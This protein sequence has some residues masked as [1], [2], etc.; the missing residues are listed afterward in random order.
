MLKIISLLTSYLFAIL[1]PLCF[2]MSYKNPLKNNFHHFHLGCPNV[3]GG[4]VY[5]VI[6][7]SPF[8]VMTKGL[9]TLWFVAFTALTAFCWNRESPNV[10]LIAIVSFIGFICF[11]QIHKELLPTNFQ[12]IFSWLL[13]NLIFCA[14]LY[15]MNLGHWYLNVHGL[16]MEHL[17]RAVTTLFGL[18]FLRFIYNGIKLTF[19]KFI[20]DG[21]WITILGFLTKFDGFF[22]N[23]AMFFGTIFPLITLCFVFETIKLKNTQSTT[24]I[25]YVILTSILLGEMAY[26][27]Y[28][29]QFGIAL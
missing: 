9:V 18:I 4:V 13:G 14:S 29:I 12:I 17:K 24:G 16:P 2:W 28:L 21:E 1:Y 3:I 23:I 5:V 8:T 7:L 20:Y 27:Y 19:P 26:K 25:L 10:N 6:L 15:A 11:L 22:L